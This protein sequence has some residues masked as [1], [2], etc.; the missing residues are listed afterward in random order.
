[1]E[2]KTKN[3]IAIIALSILS[4]AGIGWFIYDKI[5]IKRLNEKLSTPEEMQQNID[6]QLSDIPDGPIEDTPVDPD[7]MPNIEY[8]DNGE[9]I[10]TPSTD[11]VYDETPLI[12]YTKS[13]ARLRSEPSTSSTI[14]Y[15]SQL[16]E[17][18]FV[19]GTSEESDGIWYNVTDGGD[20]DGWMRNDVVT[21]D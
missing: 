9:P 20:L 3:K 17:V 5:K 21:T 2:R 15:T 11:L 8:D 12:V 1:M 19:M 4:L 18:F 13:G 10:E 14:L 6:N 7:V 16:G